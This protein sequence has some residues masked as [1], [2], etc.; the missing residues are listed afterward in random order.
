MEIRDRY[1][2][3]ISVYTDGSRDGNYVACAAIFPSNTVI[4][5]RLPDSASVFTAEMWT[6]IKTYKYIVFTDSLSC[7]QALQYIKLE[8]PLM[9]LLNVAN[10]DIMF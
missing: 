2:D 9:V 1:R 4:S 6:I 10:R 3:Y 5:M 8:H 7:L